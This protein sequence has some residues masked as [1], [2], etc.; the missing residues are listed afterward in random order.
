MKILVYRSQK[1]NFLFWFVY[2]FEV[3]AR[4]YFSMPGQRKR[5]GEKRKGETFPTRNGNRLL[6]NEIS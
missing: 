4:I 5:S 2:L 1:W 3:L 6:R